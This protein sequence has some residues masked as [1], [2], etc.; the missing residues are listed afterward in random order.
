MIFS[1]NSQLATNHTVEIGAVVLAA[2]TV[3]DRPTHQL[4]TNLDNEESS[5]VRLF[6]SL[7]PTWEGTTIEHNCHIMLLAVFEIGKGVSS[8]DASD[9]LTKRPRFEL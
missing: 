6:S 4:N 9:H 7:P 1:P 3:D 5:F 2:Y 8:L